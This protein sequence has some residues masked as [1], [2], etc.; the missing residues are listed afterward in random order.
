[1]DSLLNHHK[2]YQSITTYVES[3]CAEPAAPEGSLWLGTCGSVPELHDI[4]SSHVDGLTS[5]SYGVWY[6]DSLDPKLCWNGGGCPV[7]SQWE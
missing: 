6:P 5:P 3:L 4:D 1:M 7:D 2:N